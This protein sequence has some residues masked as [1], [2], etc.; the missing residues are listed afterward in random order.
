[1]RIRE[2]VSHNSDSNV[3]TTNDVALILN[4]NKNTVRRWSD[5]G[6]L[7][8]K[9]IGSRRDRVFKREDIDNYLSN[10]NKF[11]SNK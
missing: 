2:M 9:R 7:T 10:K 1:M 11:I 5:I 6:I 8:A 4:L 3:L